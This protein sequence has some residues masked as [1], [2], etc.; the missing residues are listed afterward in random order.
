MEYRINAL[1]Q[2]GIDTQF[3]HYSNIVHG[4]GLGIETLTK[5]WMDDAVDFWK[6]HI[7]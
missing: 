7:K 5:D 3:H 2:L 4:F 1:N 6:R